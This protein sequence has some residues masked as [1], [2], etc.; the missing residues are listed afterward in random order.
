MPVNDVVSSGRGQDIAPPAAQAVLFCASTNKRDVAM[1]N[2]VS[3]RRCKLIVGVVIWVKKIG[4]QY[5]ILW[6][7]EREIKNAK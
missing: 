2:M 4:M 5:C 3:N 6:E 1:T 7:E